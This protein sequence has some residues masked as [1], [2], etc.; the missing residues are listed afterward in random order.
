MPEPKVIG[1]IS[2]TLEEI[3]DILLGSKSSKLQNSL[4]D[5]SGSTI[6]LTE[7]VQELV[8][9]TKKQAKVNLNNTRVTTVK[10]DKILK[11]ATGSLDDIKDILSSIAYNVSDFSK[12]SGKSP[13]SDIL[14][15][16]RK[17]FTEMSKDIDRGNSKGN[18]LIS[19]IN[20]FSR[21]ST[22][23][24]KDI[25]KSKLKIK[26][27]TKTF[28]NLKKSF[29]KFKNKK[30]IEDVT[31]YSLS[32]IEIVK[33]ISKVGIFYLPAKLGVKA[34][35]V[36]FFGKN[37]LLSKLK[38]FNKSKDDI[39]K[40]KKHILDLSVI[41]GKL[42]AVT[43]MMTG[44]ALFAPAAIAGTLATIGIMWSFGKLFEK[45]GDKDRDKKMKKGGE[46]M[47]LVMTS[48]LYAGAALT[49]IAIGTKNL[50]WGQLFKVIGAVWAFG[51]L[52]MYFGKKETKKKAKDAA[53]SMAWI[54]GSMA[55][56]GAAMGVVNIATKGLKWK[57]VVLFGLTILEF[58]LI[59]KKVAENEKQIKKASV[60]MG[61]MMGSMFVAGVALGMINLATKG[62][63]FEQLLMMGLSIMTFV[64]ITQYV[65]KYD[66]KIR[67]ASVTMC[68]MMGAFTLAGLAIGVINLASRE[69]NLMQVLAVGATI[70]EFVLI[71]RYV[72]K[73]NK[74]IRTASVT[75]N[76]LMGSMIIAGLGLYL[77]NKA[78]KHMKFEQ[79]L[80]FGAGVLA[81]ASATVIISRFGDEIRK[82]AISL[83]IMMGAMVIAGAGLYLINQ[84]TK[85]M[86]WEQLGMAAVAIGGLT[87]L[88]AGAGLLDVVVGKG[89]KTIAV[90]MAAMVMA[91]A[92]LY[93]LNKGTKDMEWNQLGMAGV[94]ILGFVGIAALLGMPP[95]FAAVALGTVALGLLGISIL[96]I[97]AGV[98]L[99]GSLVDD[100]AIEKV[101][102]GIPKVIEAL[103]S[104]FGDGK[105]SNGNASFGD[106]VIGIIT[107]CLRLGGVLF[108]SAALLIASFSLVFAGLALRTWAN[109][110][111]SA[112]DNVE[113]AVGK[114]DNLFGLGF[115][116]SENMTVGG[117][118]GAALN[119][120]GNIIGLCSTLI[121]SGKVFFGMG[122]LLFASVVLGM[123]KTNLDKWKN[124]DVKSIDK[125]TKAVTKIDE[126]FGLGI[127][128]KR[129]SIA[130]KIGGIFSDAFNIVTSP[131]TLGAGLI[132]S[133]ES[134]NRLGR[135]SFAIGIVDKLADLMIKAGEKSGEMDTGLG[136]VFRAFEK[137]EKFVFKDTK[138]SLSS[139]GKSLIEKITGNDAKSRLAVMKA[140]I[141]VVDRMVESI[142]KMGN[143]SGNIDSS[144]DSTFYALEK[145]S[146]YFFADS[147]NKSSNVLKRIGKSISSA[148]ILGLWGGADKI[149]TRLE[150]LTSCVGII[151][152]MADAL[153]KMNDLSPNI[154]TSIDNV[155]YALELVSDNFFGNADKDK[156]S[157]LKKAGS[158]IRKSNLSGF[159]FGGSIKSRLEVILGCVG[160]IKSVA[161]VVEMMG[162]E[163]RDV[164]GNINKLCNALDTIVT[165][166]TA[167]VD[168]DTLDDIEDIVDEFPAIFKHIKKILDNF[169]GLDEN[170]VKNLET[171]S[172][173]CV[174]DILKVIYTF[175]SLNE[176]DVDSIEDIT[177][178]MSKIFKNVKKLLNYIPKDASS[179]IKDVSMIGSALNSFKSVD[180][181]KV[182]MS[183]KEFGKLSRGIVDV[184]SKSDFGKMKLFNSVLN[185]FSQISN[186]GGT[187]SNSVSTVV[188]K[189]NAIDIEK[190]TALRETFKSFTGLSSVG[191]FFS[192]FRKQVNLFTNACVK[193]VEAINGNTDALRS[194]TDIDETGG[195]TTIVN[196]SK[197]VAI[198][199][200]QE[201]AE[202]ITES[203]RK[204]NIGNGGFGNNDEV[205]VE[206][207]INGEGGDTWRISRI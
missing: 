28:E 29:E 110:P 181:N 25:M 158:A 60:T 66:K 188:D 34:I 85:D 204:L 32:A 165:R 122:T 130:S 51:E 39:K 78:T 160:V 193:L 145:I 36:V 135:L 118:G 101:S 21:L 119:L 47:R 91:G 45:F 172:G 44:V 49:L 163:S 120:G 31:K 109:F 89:A 42:F 30:E 10:T 79:I 20:V 76:I 117:L 105:D 53:E 9:I 143:Y 83:S 35:D 27:I 58:A 125:I 104:V 198:S 159:F 150:I 162:D 84:G 168:E 171:I 137:F 17:F 106:S 116:K 46:A 189:I 136:R 82:G 14:N 138:I 200:V 173:K 112:I 140:A 11:K 123:M 164:E 128:K 40:A 179:K 183:E 151:G 202:K 57:Q 157:V 61:I 126:F 16:P 41:S 12:K 33:K 182:I 52:T 68:I 4:Q 129:N 48:V 56:A 155:F 81:L 80:I 13:N 174:P 175:K 185:N 114:L 65:S 26:E 107:G 154:K 191:G 74:D 147:D 77:V 131:L 87:L 141:D 178:D 6:S 50:K 113:Y 144:I 97:G 94:A 177:D 23:S 75:M 196:E 55:I 19:M 90:A 103:T 86:E 43:L 72:S 161:D 201:L 142:I 62:F 194:E 70:F 5:I 67:E 205:S 207:R 203:M 95:V 102:R 3:R 124:F 22:I 37:G 197:T 170:S 156:A 111:T 59:T 176:K 133:S 54:M 187:F 69:L 99:F 180:L 18:S 115:R 1:K 100:N 166:I 127:T 7:M 184:T 2:N 132:K 92:G 73:Y 139:I 96:A 152:V 71:T 88:T 148:N 38:E 206:L 108:S 146:D 199:N 15:N 24:M 121:Q 186:S 63:K 192:N 169:E 8:D 149:E 93:L 98:A 190:A 64:G 153:S 195:T 167:N 134:F